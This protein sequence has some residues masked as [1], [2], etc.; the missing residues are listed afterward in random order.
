[1]KDNETAKLLR[2][3]LGSQRDL[4][5]A[6]G[7]R[8]STVSRWATGRTKLPQRI[9]WLIMHYVQERDRPKP[10]VEP[11]VPTP[12]HEIECPVCHHEWKTTY[13]EGVE[14]CPKC[15]ANFKVKLPENA[16]P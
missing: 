3:V 12:E 6:L 9:R 5:K 14:G 13:P 8:E 2:S 11:Y 15:Y 4:A 16:T 1:M 10:S 7:V